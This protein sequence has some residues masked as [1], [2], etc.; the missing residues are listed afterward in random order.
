MNTRVRAAIAL[1]ATVALGL[2]A[3]SKKTQM[4]KAFPDSLV[5]TEMIAI[6]NGDTITAKDIKVLAYTTTPAL[7]DSLKSR[8]FNLMLLDQMIDRSIFTQE[9]KAAGTQLPESL[10]TR[11]MTQFV[12]Q[13]GGEQKTDEVLARL[14]F[15][16]DDV[17]RAIRRDLTIRAYVKQTLEPKVAITEADARAYFDQNEAQFA[18]QDSVRVRHIIVMFHDDDNEEKRMQRRAFIEGVRQR[19]LK[20][21]DFA[22]LAKQFSEDGAAQQ[23]GDLGYFPRGSMVKEFE[24]AAFALK[25]GQISGIVETRFGYH[26]LKCEDTKKAQ[27]A[28]FEVSKPGIEEFLRQQALGADL[29]NRLKKGREVAIITRNYGGLTQ[30]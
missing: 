17:K 16:R 2:G 7:Q 5:T 24:D 19:A 14:G 28:S 4:A 20:G 26:V 1:T 15:G 9:A 22:T 8:S 23:G 11:M 18:G 21:Q 29:Q 27:P 10:V 30:R 6:V 25:K 12:G 13:F 3:C